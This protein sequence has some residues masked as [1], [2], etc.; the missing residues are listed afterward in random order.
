MT[1]AFVLLHYGIT[2]FALISSVYDIPLS[3]PGGGAHVYLIPRD[4]D[5]PLLFGAATNGQY[6]SSQYDVHHVRLEQI[7][8]NYVL[9]AVEQDKLTSYYRIDCTCEGCA[10]YQV[11]PYTRTMGKYYFLVYHFFKALLLVAALG[12]VT[13]PVSYFLMQNRKGAWVITG[14][15]CGVLVLVF[16]R[17]FAGLVLSLVR[18]VL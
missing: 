18:E 9:V 13:F 10:L 16:G 5:D 2:S 6:F 15:S 1:S 4:L 12:V 14:V 17:I 7:N 8:F 3:I 11:S